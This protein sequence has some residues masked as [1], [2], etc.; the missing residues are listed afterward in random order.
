MAK[1]DS[2]RR[3]DERLIAVYKQHGVKT[4][5]DVCSEMLNIKDKE[6]WNKKKTSNGEVCE[7]VLRVL[8]DHYLKTRSQTGCT[9]HS[10]ILA[11]R[12]GTSKDFRTELDFTL[13]T[14]GF[15]VTGEC[16]SFVG[17]II[18]SGDC[19]LTRDTMV[20]DVAKQSLL[21][22]KCLRQYLEEYSLP[23]AGLAVPPYGLFCFVYSNGSLKDTRAQRQRD[24]I[25]V[26]TIKTLYGYYDGLFRRFD[27]RVYDYE[28]AKKQ[29]TNFAKS[30][31][32]HRQHKEFLGY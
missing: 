17:D 26:L 27:K 23:G 8:T 6:N 1:N 32:L 28:R 30:E 20:A 18:V 2:E 25:P 22:G 12:K 11:D 9:F 5:L 19:T 7:V 13:L 21:H 24:T 4:F 15:C 3:L 14:P 16:K 10:M 31:A 29:F